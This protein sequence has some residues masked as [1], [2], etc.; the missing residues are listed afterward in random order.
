MFIRLY[1]SFLYS[2]Y[3]LNLIIKKIESK[4]VLNTSL[5][6]NMEYELVKVDNLYHVVDANDNYVK[7]ANGNIIVFL[8]TDDG[9]IGDNDNLNYDEE[10]DCFYDSE[11]NLYYIRYDDYCEEE[12]KEKIV[13]KQIWV[14][15]KN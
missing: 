5:K 1:L 14:P 4:I 13:K 11:N 3:I 9:F 8:E 2:E 15:K 6:Q 7:N 10:L 12:E